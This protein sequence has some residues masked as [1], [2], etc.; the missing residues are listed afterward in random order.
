MMM[1]ARI[2]NRQGLGLFALLGVLLLIPVMLRLL[3]RHRWFENREQEAAR[4]VEKLAARRLGPDAARLPRGVY[5]FRL[6]ISDDDDL[7]GQHAGVG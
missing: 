4:L 1:K 6:F 2:R 3:S 5:L 7:A